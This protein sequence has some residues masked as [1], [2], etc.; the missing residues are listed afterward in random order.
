M[1]VDAAAFVPTNPLDLSRHQPDFVVVSFYKMFGCPT[2]LGCLLV[3]ADAIDVLQDSY[4]GGGQV[5]LA[6][7]GSDFR[8]MHCQPS[9]RLEDGT[10]AFLDIASIK[11]GFA[12]IEAS[13]CG[14]CVDLI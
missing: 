7:A 2:G 12:A 14:C 6:T 3:R 13:C 4:W 11:H 10:Q 8:V 1:L 5:A 9:E